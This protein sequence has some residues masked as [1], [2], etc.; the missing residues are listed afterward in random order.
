[1]GNKLAIFIDGR[2][3]K[4]ATF[5]SLNIKVDFVKLRQH[6]TGD[7]FLVRAY[8]YSGVWTEESI[9]QFINLKGYENRDEKFEE[10][11]QKR[12]RDLSFLRF[13]NRN[14]YK[15]VTKP[16][17]VYR[18][19]TTGEVSIKADLDVELAIDMLKL[20]DFVDACILA[21]GDGDFVPVINEVAAKGVRV[22]VLA[23]QSD[24]AA[25]NGYRASDELIDAADEFIDIV[26]IRPFIERGARNS[27]PVADV[28]LNDETEG[29]VIEE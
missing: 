25:Q 21:S 4:Y 8:Y 7:N 6:L 13:L 27:A 23:T 16:M 15:V 2:N 17:K 24:E 12:D 1:M 10:F 26:K 22:A 18:D 9:R 29:F 5:D 19:F 3:F 28:R 20:A 14:G 11:M